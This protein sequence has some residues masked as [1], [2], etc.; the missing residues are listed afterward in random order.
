M[1]EIEIRK[2]IGSGEAIEDICRREGCTPSALIRRLLRPADRVI[3][4]DELRDQ[5]GVRPGISGENL[6]AAKKITK[7]SNETLARAIGASKETV[8]LMLK[9][10]T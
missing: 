9:L 8:R 7:A 3:T 4:A 5:Y 1:N 6:L 10:A 2:A